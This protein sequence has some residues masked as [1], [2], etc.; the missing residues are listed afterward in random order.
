MNAQ[1]TRRALLALTLPTLLA[2]SAC[3]VETATFMVGTLERDRIELKVESNEPI[4]GIHVSDGQA[5]AVGDLVLSQDPTRAQARLAQAA[6]AR[7]A[8][9]SEQVAARAEQEALAKAHGAAV[10][11]GQDARRDLGNLVRQAYTSGPSEWTLI[12][13]FLDADGPADALRRASL[14]TLLAALHPK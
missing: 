3:D 14:S 7:D 12:A 2:V 4:V 5:V 1:Q 6:S 9:L 11:A 13:S 8:A 10:L